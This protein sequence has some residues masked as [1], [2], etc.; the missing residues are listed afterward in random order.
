M[1]PT[2]V[3]GDHFTAPICVTYT[4]VADGVQV[5]EIPSF[6][7]FFERNPDDE[8]EFSDFIWSEGNFS[9]DCNRHLFFERASGRDPAPGSDTCGDGAYRVTITDP[10][11]GRV[12][13]DEPPGPHGGDR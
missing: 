4:R 11:T 9:C 10:D 2:W 3:G 5:S 1:R 8:F 12:W 7:G 6:P 13:Y